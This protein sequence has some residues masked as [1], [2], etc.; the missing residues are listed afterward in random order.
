MRNITENP[1]GG[2]V[3]ISLEDPQDSEGL[4]KKIAVRAYEIFERR[5]R[6]PNHDVDDWLAAESEVRWELH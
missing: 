6:V 4:K 2:L 1:R 3:P 5:G